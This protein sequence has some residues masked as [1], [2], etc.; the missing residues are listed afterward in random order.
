M[1]LSGG[2]YRAATYH[3]GVL[4][5]LHKVGLLDKVT[6]ISS[7]SGGS[8]TALK[9]ASNLAE[10]GNF[11]DFST[12]LEGFLTGRD[13]I[14][15]ASKLLG[16][17]TYERVTKSY[18]IITAFSELYNKH[19]FGESSK[20]FNLFW[21]KNF[22]NSHLKELAVNATEFHSGNS[23]RFTKS[24]SGRAKIGNKNISLLADDAKKLR[25]GDILAASSCFPGGFEP[26]DLLN[27]FA[28]SEPFKRDYKKHWDVE[29]L[30]LMDG[31]IYD[32]Q[33]L[34]AIKLAK[35]RN[36]PFDLIIISDSD[37]DKDYPLYSPKVTPINLPNWTLKKAFSILAV[38]S[39]T[40]YFFASLGVYLAFTSFL[41]RDL[42][43]SFLLVSNIWI[44]RL[45]VFQFRS[46]NESLNKAVSNQ[47]DPALKKLS[48]LSLN[49]LA[50][51]LFS[52][53]QS[54]IT[55]TTSVFMKRIR[56]LVYDSVYKP[57]RFRKYVV[58]NLIYS[59][60]EKAEIEGY[61]ITD[62]MLDK[63]KTA[64]EMPTTLWFTDKDQSQYRA[65]KETG[66]FT[67]AYKLIEYIDTLLPRF[68]EKKKE[69]L[70]LIRDKL[71]TVW[72]S[73]CNQ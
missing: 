35:K 17:P 13:L 29:S 60:D 15:E 34:E 30:Y 4:T 40:I 14:S 41:A 7:V 57:G 62:Q 16:K 2:G 52:R 67:T 44:F 39:L 68:G 48:S 38:L 9:Y 72:F 37:Q 31:G 53:G 10:G 51:A 25:L 56:S 5:C 33:G 50:D 63:V 28:I 24:Q 3:F 20:N 26:I 21:N 18:T 1:A 36:N 54:L 32:N 45:V 69:E 12:Q 55:M 64:K 42:V 66:E 22:K 46:F 43:L 71:L 19:L 61:K 11:D 70:D 73:H 6:M 27:D 47:F 23:F 65:L 59:L 49:D 58:D 8:I